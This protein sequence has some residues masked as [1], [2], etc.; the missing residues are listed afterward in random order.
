MKIVVVDY[1]GGNGKSVCNA[2]AK[3]GFQA[4]LSQDV[5]QI[6]QADLI[7]LPGVGAAYAT[8]KSLSDLGLI[9]KIKES[10]FSKK[11]SFLGI[12]VGYQILFE[13]SEEDDTPCLG[14]VKGNVVRYNSQHVKVPHMGWN[15]VR[16]SKYCPKEI[17]REMNGKQYYYFVNSYYGNPVDKKI[18]AGESFYENW[19]NCFFIK[20][21]IAATQFHL[22]KSGQQ[23]L[24]LLKNLSTYLVKKKL[25][26]VN[27]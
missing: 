10:I 12:C 20:D 9:Q 18:V 19:F 16:F 5:S 8:L 6:S 14:A 11:N 25:Q 26:N 17:L 15:E 2:Y 21:H 7:V 27:S 4:Q 24:T 22:E 23:G 1:H 13:H 3:I